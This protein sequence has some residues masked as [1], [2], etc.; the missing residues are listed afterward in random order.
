MPADAGAAEPG[1]HVGNTWQ[2]DVS[3]LTLRVASCRGF[4][5]VALRIL[6]AQRR[7]GMTANLI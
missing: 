4:C 5:S 6:D 3:H 1:T 7:A 2:D